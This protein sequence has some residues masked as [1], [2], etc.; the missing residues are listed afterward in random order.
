MPKYCWNLITI[1]SNSNPDELNTL[2]SDEFENIV[3]GMIQYKCEIIKKGRRGIVLRKWSLWNPNF[4]WLEGLLDKY[5]SCW[6][7]NNWYEE[8]GGAGIWI[9]YVQHEE[10]QIK[11]MEWDDLSAEEKHFFFLNDDSDTYYIDIYDDEIDV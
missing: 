9:G 5:P 10:K 7:K 11:R 8:G 4:E 3:D 6:I 2:I 1:V